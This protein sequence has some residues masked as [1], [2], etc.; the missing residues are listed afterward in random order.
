MEEDEYYEKYIK[1]KNKYEKLKKKN[2][3]LIALNATIKNKKKV[4]SNKSKTWKDLEYGLMSILSPKVGNKLKGG[5]FKIIKRAIT[6]ATKTFIPGIGLVSNLIENPTNSSSIFNTFQFN[7]FIFKKFENSK[8]HN[9][10]KKMLEL[11]DIDD[12]YISIINPKI[13]KDFTGKISHL[14]TKQARNNVNFLNEQ[15]PDLDEELV[16]FVWHK[17][18]IDLS[19]ISLKKNKIRRNKEFVTSDNDN[20]R[21]LQG[22]IKD[23][24]NINEKRIKHLKNLENFHT[25]AHENNNFFLKNIIHN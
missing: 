4:S 7:D 21:Y 22:L 20:M 13:L 18:N 17:Y 10:L 19:E 23:R 3:K 2:E 5:I 24:E 25:K 8:S 6:V 9:H 1:Y 14:V 11:I 12:D 15:I 16:D